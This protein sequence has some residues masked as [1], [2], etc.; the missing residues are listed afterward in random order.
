MN[1]DLIMN[2]FRIASRELFNH[3]F[4]V[5][6]PWNNDGWALEARFSEVEATLFQAIVLDPVRQIELMYG[7]HQPSIRVEL[8]SQF[9][10]VMINRD[11]DSGYWDFPIRT[12]T[13]TARMSFV[14]FF[15]WD[16]LSFRDYQYVRVVIDEWS[17]HP[18]CAGK[19]ALV[20]SQSV[21]FRMAD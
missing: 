17:E 21:A 8:R 14:R 4:R 15:D 18:E 12:V 9:A 1:F 10:P 6:D 19:H 16:L 2:R 20:D 13:S 11:Q 3:H 7:Q 5:D